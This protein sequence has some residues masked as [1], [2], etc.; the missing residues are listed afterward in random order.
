MN[1]MSENNI[2]YSQIQN[3]ENIMKWG[4]TITIS[5]NKK[6]LYVS[7]ELNWSLAMNSLNVFFFSLYHMQNR[8]L[9]DTVFAWKIWA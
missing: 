2:S 7:M 8:K 4:S 1:K 3:N 9:E 5:Y 6:N